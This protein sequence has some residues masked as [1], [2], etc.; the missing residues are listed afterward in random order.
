[1]FL[2]QIDGLKGRAR[3][4]GAPRFLQ[5]SFTEGRKGNEATGGRL[6]QA[7][8]QSL[9][10]PLMTKLHRRFAIFPVRRSFGEGGCSRTAIC[11]EKTYAPSVILSAAKN[12]ERCGQPISSG[13]F[14]ALRMTNEVA[15]KERKDP[16]EFLCDPSWLKDPVRIEN[17]STI[18]CHSGRSEESRFCGRGALTPLR[19][20]GAPRFL[21]NNFYR[22]PQRSRRRPLSCQT[23]LG[24][25]CDLS[26]KKGNYSSKGNEAAVVR[27]QPRTNGSRKQ[28]LKVERGVPDA[29]GLV[30]GVADPGL[31]TLVNKADPGLNEAGYIGGVGV[32]RKTSKH[33]ETEPTPGERVGTPRST[34]FQVSVTVNGEPITANA[35]PARS[36]VTILSHASDTDRSQKSHTID[37]LLRHSWGIFL[38][39]TG[40]SL[41]GRSFDCSRG[42]P[43][44]T[45]TTS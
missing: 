39:E 30:A 4:P 42:A 12:P 17:I 44:Q 18:S 38:G 1:M 33:K 27:L 6:R 20:V 45:I 9:F 11:T 24:V 5:S 10:L 28:T 31:T 13:F 26:V 36:F 37:G 14:A 2:F 21:P 41:L 7:S 8:K 43:F 35:A 3:P 15:T 29:L 23:D 34:S 16:G 22:R 25:L 32:F 40:E 19:M